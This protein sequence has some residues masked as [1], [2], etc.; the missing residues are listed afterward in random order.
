MLLQLLVQFVEV[1]NE[2]MSTGRSEVT[3]RVNHK[4]WV[5]ALFGVK[6][7]NSGSSTRHIFIG[8]LS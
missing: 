6:G 5:V 3:F 2:V 1:C 8:K 4:V 7:R